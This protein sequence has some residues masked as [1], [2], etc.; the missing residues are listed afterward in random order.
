MFYFGRTSAGIENCV[1]GPVHTGRFRQ[2]FLSLTRQ[3]F[4]PNLPVYADP[5]GKQADILGS[6]AQ[7]GHKQ[8]KVVVYASRTLTDV[9]A[10]HTKGADRLG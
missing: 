1:W 6:G 2:Q 9:E 3:I 8:L 4:Q 7:D 5:K 10:H